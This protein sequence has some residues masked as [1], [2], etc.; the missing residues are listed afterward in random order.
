MKKMFCLFVF[1]Y[2]TAFSQTINPSK[3]YINTCYNK[4]QCFSVNENDGCFLFYNKEQQELSLLI[5]FNKFKIGNDSLDE[6]LDDLDDSHFIFKGNIKNQK[7][8]ELSPNNSTSI[9]L[10]GIINFNNVASS[11]S[12]ELTFF[13]ISNQG[14]LFHDNGQD[15][16]DRVQANIILSFYPREFKIDKKP[17]HLKKA[18][19]ISI[20]RGYLNLFKPELEYL[21]DKK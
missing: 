14:V 13:E 7:I 8:L 17:H 3:A 1:F 11:H 15:F 4:H 20:Y 10:N 19:T 2:C 18:I 6:W 16:L 12:I 5:D 9:I 21:F